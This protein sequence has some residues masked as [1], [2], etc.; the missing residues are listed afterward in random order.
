MPLFWQLTITQEETVL[1]QRQ[2][3]YYWKK[4]NSQLANALLRKFSRFSYTRAFLNAEI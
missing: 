2:M 3:A 1:S 4:L